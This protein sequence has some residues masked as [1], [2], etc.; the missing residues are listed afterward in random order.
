MIAD[1][2]IFNSMKNISTG[3]L[4]QILN[5]IFSFIN[6]TVFI[7]TLGATYLGVNGL[8]TNILSVLS[9]AELGVGNAIIYSMYKPLAE[10][11]EKK[12][13]GLMKLYADIYHI[14]GCIVGILGIC[15]LPFLNYI[16]KDI[17][18]IPNI[19]FIYLIFL[20]NSVI[21]YFFAYKKS[22]ITADQKGY[23]ISVY[24]YIFNIIQIII[25]I[26][27]LKVTNN[28]ILYLI[29][30]SVFIIINNI[31]ISYKANK[32]YHFL[33]DDNI[34]EIDRFER[35]NIFKNIY[36]IL[37]YK[38]NAII[39]NSTD[40][41]IISA[42]IGIKS[43]GLYSNY[44]MITNSVV[45]IL[46]IIFNALTASIGNLNA[47]ESTNKKYEIYNTINFV[48]FWL[49]GL[50]A[51]CLYVLLNP[52]IELW[53]GKEYVMDSVVVLAI[54]LNLYTT[55]MQYGT[56]TYRDTTGLFW[57]GRYVPIF[58]S[59]IN[60]FFSVILAK[61]IGIAGVLFATIISRILTYFWF[62]P[63]VLYK[64]IF[65]RPV[66]LYFYRYFKYLSITMITMFIT[67]YLCLLTNNFILKVIA[68]TTIPNIIFIIAFYKST[69]FKYINS[70][71]KL[72]ANRFNI[73]EKLNILKVNK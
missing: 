6:R 17:P 26:I 28:F 29:T 63:F 16:I 33:K 55:G 2:R 37:M 69:E 68:C 46:S 57:Y 72:I 45:M 50:S 67:N 3:M 13:K 35:K 54:I 23:I 53:L 34:E 8:F 51:I 48:S 7:Q 11:D 59:V 49:Y 56:S 32:M 1:S 15:I 62:D 44:L 73:L 20:M 10:N 61:T 65:K 58:A 36:A 70:V 21:G 27:I 66:N 22:I 5:L 4:G 19:R 30:Q 41:I 64:K 71:F 42:F 25:Q 31:V 24:Q 60:L 47:R 18:D 38:I 39:L 43:V 12:L 40:N 52:F 9:I 14:I